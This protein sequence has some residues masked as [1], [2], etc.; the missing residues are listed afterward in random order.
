MYIFNTIGLFQVSQI[1]ID[2]INKNIIISPRQAS[3]FSNC[4]HRSKVAF[5]F[6]DGPHPITTPIIVKTLNEHRIKGGF[7]VLGTSIQ[8]FLSARNLLTVHQF[9]RPSLPFLLLQNYSSLDVLFEGHDI[10]LHGW[11]HERNEEMR[12]QTVVNNIAIQLIE[13]GHLKAFKPIYRAPW[14]IPTTPKHVKDNVLLVQILKQMG[15]TAAYWDIDTKDWQQQVN[16]NTLIGSS[17]KMICKKKGGHILMHDNRPTTAN[18]LDRFIRSIKDSGHMI[19][20]PTEI[21]SIWNDKKAIVTNRKYIE[22][23]RKKVRNAQRNQS[24]NI[25]YRNIF[26][27]VEISLGTTKM[28]LTLL[29]NIYSTDKYKDTVNVSPNINNIYDHIYLE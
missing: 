13:I 6:D 8:S 17:L 12:L 11:L 2:D 28:K 10:Y 23:I 24:K 7:F 21:N 16:E 15:I 4:S 3:I 18:F 25:N 9:E 27:P 19:V 20:S 26:N 1:S 22:I 14:G 5:T 29:K